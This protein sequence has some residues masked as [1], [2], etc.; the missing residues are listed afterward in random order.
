[1]R[2]HY[3]KPFCP[4][5]DALNFN[6]SLLIFSPIDGQSLISLAIIWW[7][8]F[9]VFP[10]VCSGRPSLLFAEIYGPSIAT[11][12]VCPP[13]VSW[14]SDWP[15]RTVAIRKSQAAEWNR[16]TFPCR[17]FDDIGS[18]RMS[19]TGVHNIGWQV[20]VIQATCSFIPMLPPSPSRPSSTSPRPHWLVL[21]CQ[22]H[23]QDFDDP[24]GQSVCPYPSCHHQIRP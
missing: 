18:V 7:I 4:S 1:M 19:L 17:L 6:C 22:A 23:H 13:S 11:L 3:T 15:R 5:H 2:R 8:F 24:R 12:P 9:P 16:R 20:Q 21:F 14:C 10:I